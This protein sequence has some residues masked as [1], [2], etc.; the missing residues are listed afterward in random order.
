MAAVFGSGIRNRREYYLHTHL[1]EQPDL[2]WR[3]PQVRQAMFDVMRFWFDR[4]VDGFRIDAMTHLIKDERFRDNP[5]NPEYHASLPPSHQLKDA[6]QQTNRK[7]TKSLKICGRS[8]TSTMT[9]C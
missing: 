4:G 3:N 2:N 9:A 6:G 8:R 1:R 7:F 5:L